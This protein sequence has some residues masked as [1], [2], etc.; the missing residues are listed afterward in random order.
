MQ[1][2]ILTLQADSK[3]LLD[4]NGEISRERNDERTSLQN[5]FSSLV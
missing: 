4:R 3:K 1:D 2:Q 5:V